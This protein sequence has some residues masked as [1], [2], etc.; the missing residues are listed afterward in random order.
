MKIRLNLVLHS[1]IISA[2]S[3][4]EITNAADDDLEQRWLKA[5]TLFFYSSLERNR[6]FIL[7]KVLIS[8]FRRETELSNQINYRQQKFTLKI[9]LLSLN[10]GTVLN[11]FT[12]GSEETSWV[13]LVQVYT[14]TQRVIQFYYLYKLKLTN[15]YL[16]LHWQAGWTR[17]PLYLFDETSFVK[18]K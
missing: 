9:K 13:H 5:I 16:L 6:N 12:I 10:D 7:R 17:L 15:L 14:Q 3:L 2:Y 4:M 18:E 11:C 8:Y 1:L